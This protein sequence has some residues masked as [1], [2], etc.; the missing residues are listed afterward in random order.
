MG[1]SFTTTLIIEQII[2]QNVS[3][4]PSFIA[5]YANYIFSPANLSMTYLRESARLK[6]ILPYL[7]LMGKSMGKC[8]CHCHRFDQIA[9][10]A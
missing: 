3:H 6:S 5:L 4:P 1:T 2:A 9:L 7:N 10:L 8:H